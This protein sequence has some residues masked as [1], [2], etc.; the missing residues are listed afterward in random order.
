MRDALVNAKTATMGRKK[1]ERRV[2]GPVPR[3]AT[4]AL[5]VSPVARFFRTR[6]TTLLYLLRFALLAGVE[7]T[8][9][10][11]PYD[12]RGLAAACLHLYL[13]AYAHLAGGALSLVDSSVH[14]VGTD[15]LGRFN[16]TFAMNC[17]AMD[18][19]IL[20]SS[21]VI[22]FP[23]TARRRTVGLAAGLLALVAIN[24]V[25]IVSLY[26]VGVHF[27]SAFEFCHVDL[28]PI[29]IV[30]VTCAGFLAWAR[31]AGVGRPGELNVSQA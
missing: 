30:A 29:F 6:K 4:P 11:F 20:F 28:W 1:A 12:P 25:R 9:Y 14:V 15:I 19:F 18:V 5:P 26:L 22:A 13:A 23:S 8:A 21:A 17:D 7:L 31:S 24:V 2:R 10:Y 16:L 27:P 3:Q